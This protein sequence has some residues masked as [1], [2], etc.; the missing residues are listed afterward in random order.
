MDNFSKEGEMDEASAENPLTRAS[1]LTT[2]VRRRMYKRAVRDLKNV[3]MRSR[4]SLAK[5]NFTVDLVST[6]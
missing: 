2:K 6:I 4:E 5:L 3:Q 1:H